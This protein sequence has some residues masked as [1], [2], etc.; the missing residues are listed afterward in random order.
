MQRTFLR[1]LRLGP[2]LAIVFAVAVVLA[3]GFLTWAHRW[4]WRGTFAPKGL[5]DE[6]HNVQTEDGW[7]LG[8]RRYR[9]RGSGPRYAEPVILCHGLGA[10]HYNLDWDPPNGIAQA[11]AE[12]GRDC[13][14]IC[15]RGHD[16]SDRPS[17]FNELRWGFSFDDYLRYD[18]PAS[19]EYVL[20]ATGAGRAQWVGHSMGGILAYALGGTPLEERLG[21][22]VVAI[23]SP[24][25]YSNQPYLRWIARLGRWLAGS[26]RIRQR[27]VTQL[28]APFAGFIDPPFSELVIAPRSMNGKVV[29]RL[30]AWAFEDMSAGVIRQFEDW[31]WNDAFRSLDK[32]RDY[33]A[34]MSAFSAP[35]LLIGGEKDRMVPP[36]CMEAALA[37]LGSVDKT[38]VI[39]GK[40]HGQGE[41]YG[42]GDLLLG[43]AAPG[44]V[45]PRVAAWL[46]AR[47]TVSEGAPHGRS[48]AG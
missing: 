25:S 6:V 15:L 7:R 24:A 31:V 30:Q 41:E 26:T 22:G 21:G 12:Q 29:R 36:A 37:R 20:S 34:C 47:A 45:Y 23:A 27:V 13:W 1:E 17:F 40:S 39:L 46:A 32:R 42:H 19:I 33:R 28:I 16:G 14:V 10:N 3:L 38:L 2:A 8:L 43:V 11:L 9:P 4:F 18:V 44:E 48:P 35:L 5:P